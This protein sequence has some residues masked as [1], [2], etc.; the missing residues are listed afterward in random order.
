MSAIII[1]SNHTVKGSFPH[2]KYKKRLNST[3]EFRC[4]LRPTLLWNWNQTSHA[5]RTTYFL[6]KNKIKNLLQRDNLIKPK[7]QV[8]R[9]YYKCTN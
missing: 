7:L 8:N 5:K 4:Y 3:F 9:F 6:L 2:D 1:M